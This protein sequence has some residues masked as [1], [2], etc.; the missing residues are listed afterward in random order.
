MDLL[1]TLNDMIL[2]L[3]D[4]SGKSIFNLFC[5]GKNINGGEENAEFS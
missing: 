2:D 5:I 4:L 1:C 3:K